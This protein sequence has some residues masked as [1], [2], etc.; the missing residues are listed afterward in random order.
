M[1]YNQKPQTLLG[2][3]IGALLRRNSEYLDSG[4]FRITP[5]FD[6]PIHTW[7]RD[8][9][10]HIN[11]SVHSATEVG[12]RLAF[13]ANSIIRHPLLGGFASLQNMLMWSIVRYHPESDSIRWTSGTQ[14]VPVYTNLVNECVQIGCLQSAPVNKVAI[15]AAH[16]M[17]VLRY[18][19][20]LFEEFQNVDIPYDSYMVSSSG[21]RYRDDYTT[22]AWYLNTLDVIQKHVVLDAKLGFPDLELFVK[23]G[24]AETMYDEILPAY[25]LDAILQQREAKKMEAAAL[26][27]E[28][29]PAQELTPEQKQRKKNRNKNKNK[30]RNK[31]RAAMQDGLLEDL[32]ELDKEHAS[33]VLDD[34]DKRA[35]AIEV[36]TTINDPAPL[37]ADQAKAFAEV[38]EDSQPEVPYRSYFTHESEQPSA[39]A[40]TTQE[41]PL[42]ETQPT[43]STEQNPPQ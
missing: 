13:A 21:L 39:Q 5:H 26:E 10:D 23:S 6:K 27:S 3:I 25:Q 11:L 34:L 24:T 22:P 32:D 42:V 19:T 28:A 16:I 30:N 2:K 35:A 7:A 9:D 18:D 40:D 14:R 43:Q 4:A 8:G 12:Y 31:N 17:N 33:F 15:A 36:G 37:S 38:F 29:E 1:T 20:K 41:A